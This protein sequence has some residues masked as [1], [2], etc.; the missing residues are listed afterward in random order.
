MRRDLA[1]AGL[2]LAALATACQQQA[3]ATVDRVAA[4]PATAAS[5]PSVKQA[6]PFPAAP[7]PPSSKCS[8]SDFTLEPS[9][10]GA[11]GSVLLGARLV[12]RAGLKPCVARVDITVSLVH[13]STGRLLKI[14]NNPARTR[15]A[16]TLGLDDQEVLTDTIVW[17]E[18]FCANADD[19]ELSVV[20][21][22]GHHAAIPVQVTPRC[23]PTVGQQGSG[24]G[25]G[26]V[27]PG[28]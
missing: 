28:G 12:E 4:P 22:V 20:D 13:R 9:A 2:L 27:R 26:V 11:T 10:D 18:P 19:L 24:P 1:A 7:R 25:L 23:D 14:R 17:G 5:L 16:G 6:S 3:Q 8:R 15:A 21:N